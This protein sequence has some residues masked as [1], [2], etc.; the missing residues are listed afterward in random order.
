LPSEV[1]RNK[2]YPV[3]AYADKVA[4][5]AMQEINCCVAIVAYREKC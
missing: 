2:T 4:E 3:L 1:K 5:K